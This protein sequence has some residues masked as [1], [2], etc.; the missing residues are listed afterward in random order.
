MEMHQ[1]RYF[2]AV[3][4]ILNFTQAAAECNVSQPALSRAIKQLEEE[5]GGDLF[6]RERSLTH[7]TE[8]GRMMQPLLTQ[9]YDTAT[10][11]KALASSYRKGNYAPLRLALSNTIDLRLLIDPLSKL[12]DAL[13]G[14]ELKFFRG[15][16]DAVC[17]ALKNG[18]FEL[19]I[20]GTMPS[21]W[22]RLRSWPLFTTT[23]SLVLHKSHQLAAR[24]A[25]S[26]GQLT[27]ERLI[28]R[29][30]CEM[31][32]ALAQLLLENGIHQAKNDAVGSDQ[33][34]LTLVAANV[35]LAFMPSCTAISEDLRAVPVEGLD[36]VCPVQ[37]YA[38]TGRQHSPAASGLIQL[39][40]AA[41]W[42]ER[43][44]IAQSGVPT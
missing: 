26:L 13:P 9:A 25:V 35:G 33:D 16:A 4:R 28:S 32:G 23:F 19:A 5:L 6:R 37:L 3:A 8:L 39:L 14:V 15:D 43:L 30:Y 38:V 40:R 10:S 11:A 34:V 44:A 29:P 18:E 21:G 27:G 42:E 20:A 41:N 1:I 2:L 36:L 17:D 31:A 24:N 22:D 7:L 12:I